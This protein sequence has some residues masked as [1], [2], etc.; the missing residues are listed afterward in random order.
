MLQLNNGMLFAQK[1]V[2]FLQHLNGIRRLGQELPQDKTRFGT[3]R[4]AN[5]NL[6]GPFG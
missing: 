3:Q 4:F 6:L 5:A 2:V 1:H